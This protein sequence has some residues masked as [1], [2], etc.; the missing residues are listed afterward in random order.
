MKYNSRER[1]EWNAA[2]RR[3][4]DEN[5]PMPERADALA[6]A[7]YSH[8]QAKRRMA[9]EEGPK[10]GRPKELFPSEMCHEPNCQLAAHWC[11]KW[12]AGDRLMS[13][14]MCNSHTIKKVTF[15]EGATF[16]LLCKS[17]TKSGKLAQRSYWARKR[18][19]A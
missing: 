18:R 9:E 19:F 3:A 7:V 11:V 5:L 14:C 13:R 2:I 4:R 10:R 6:A 8:L 15:T 1:K 17:D 16:K 12:T